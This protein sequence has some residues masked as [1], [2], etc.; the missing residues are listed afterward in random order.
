MENGEPYFISKD[1]VKITREEFL[2][3]PFKVDDR[4]IL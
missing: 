2:Y 1:G 3:P 4:R